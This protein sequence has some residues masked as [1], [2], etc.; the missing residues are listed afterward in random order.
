MESN[1]SALSAGAAFLTALALAGPVRAQE[2]PAAGALSLNVRRIGLEISSTRVENAED[3]QATSSPVAD[4][5]ADG[6]SVVKGVWDTILEYK[7]DDRRW[8]NG[9]YMEY[10]KTTLKPAAGPDT[11]SET[12]DKILFTS[13]YAHKI[14]DVRGMKLGPMVVGEYQTEFVANAG[15][16]RTS[17]L[18]AKSG[19]TLFDG[20]AVK[21][22]YAAAVAEG[23]M[24]Y[25]PAIY[26][27]GAEIGARVEYQVRDGVKA[28][29][30]AYGRRYFA[31]SSFNAA[32]LK[33][34][35][36]AKA[37]L[38]VALVDGLALGPYVSY[39][40]AQQRAKGS[41]AG[42]NIMIG[43]SIAYQGLFGL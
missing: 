6:Q 15:A 13:D 14:W 43:L 27:A 7:A 10:A 35:L 36:S 41:P 4:L 8:D 34:D 24:S 9:L 12:A 29:L 39:R 22:L 32:D 40:L 1:I 20:A 17:I 30:D 11:K 18:R 31:F 25:N 33:Y 42:S 2:A 38:D 5:T 19:V 23:D 16:R 28:S 37:Y 3:Y 26:K 21:N